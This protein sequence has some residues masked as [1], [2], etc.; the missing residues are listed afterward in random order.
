MKYP[1]L[2]YP[3]HSSSAE[4]KMVSKTLLVATQ[5][6]FHCPEGVTNGSFLLD[7]HRPEIFGP[8][9]HTARSERSPSHGTRTSVKTVSS[10]ETKNGQSKWEGWI[11]FA[12]GKSSIKKRFLR[13]KVNFFSKFGSESPPKLGTFL[14][15]SGSNYWCRGCKNVDGKCLF[16]FPGDFDNK[17]PQIAFTGGLR[18][19]FRAISWYFKQRYHTFLPDK[20]CGLY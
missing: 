15:T 12:S 2:D 5:S 19:I 14:G 17:L 4:R 7:K 10:R 11:H 16:I 8:S 6:P 13:S 3:L 20:V 1:T 18:V 9:L